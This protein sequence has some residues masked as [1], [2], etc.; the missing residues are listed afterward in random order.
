MT[1]GDILREDFRSELFAPIEEAREHV[2]KR[3]LISVWCL[4]VIYVFL[5]GAFWIPI[6]FFVTMLGAFVISPLILWMN[7]QGSIH[8]AKI[9]FVVS[10]NFYIYFASLG[11][12]HEVSAEY[13][14]LPLTMV[15]LVLFKLVQKIEIWGSVLLSFSLWFVGAFFGFTFLPNSFV[16]STNQTQFFEYFN[17]IGAFLI[18]L[19]VLSLFMASN[20]RLQKLLISRYEIDSER[21]RKII[22]ALEHKTAQLRSLIDGIPA[23]VSHWDTEMTNLAANAKYS[24]YF[25]KSPE[26][27]VGL[28]YRD[29]IGAIFP[30]VLPFVE[31]ALAGKPST[32]QTELLLDDGSKKYFRVIFSPEMDGGEVKGFFT[33]A[34][35]ETELRALERKVEEAR[36]QSIQQAKLASLGEMSAGIAHEINNPLAIVVGTATQM[37]RVLDD[38]EKMQ[39]KIKAI[40]RACER[41]SRIV[42]SLRKFS[43]SGDKPEYLSHDM[44]RILDEVM[45]LVDSKAKR[46]ETSLTLDCLV[47]PQ[48]LCD[49][50]EIEQVLINLINNAI[51]A[52]KISPENW[53]KVSVLEEGGGQVVL[54]VIDSGLGVPSHLIDRVFEPFF[55]TKEIGEGTGLGLSISKGIL[56]EHHGSLTLLE[57]TPNTCFEV[58][59]PKLKSDSA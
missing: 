50:V 17:F 9:L 26:Q 48:I 51:D 25:K 29:V 42:S 15:P 27:M 41:I 35:D 53:V 24:A 54:R 18:S 39:T 5:F 28:K 31:Q 56:T 19:I 8:G 59:L 38:P 1:S 30:L 22:R 46:H 3:L 12:A 44:R 20:F 52:A 6:S 36:I 43:R 10:C 34:I 14:Y 23:L 58:R 11:L 55:T 7:R 45:T 4:L 21:E 40:Q 2:F 32:T 57:N 13:Y 47:A 49:E 37:T 33:I 16:S